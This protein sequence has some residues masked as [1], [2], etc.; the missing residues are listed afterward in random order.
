M[1]AMTTAALI[2]CPELPSSGLR[3]SMYNPA[4]LLDLL[5]IYNSPAVGEGD[6]ISTRITTSLISDAI[7]NL[8]PTS[9]YGVFA[10]SDCY[11]EMPSIQVLKTNKTRYWQLGAIFEDEGTLSGTYAVHRNIFIDQLRLRKSATPTKYDDFHDRLWLVHGDQLISHHIRSVKA[12]QTEALL[13][14]DR[15]DWMLG[16]PAWFHIQMNLLNTIVRT[17]WASDYSGYEAH[18]CLSADITMWNRSCSSR[19]N[20]KYHQI[21]PIATQGF[22]GRVAALFYSA[23]QERGYFNGCNDNFLANTDYINEIISSLKPPQF[24]QLVED[25]RLAAFTLNAWNGDGLDK[26]PHNDTEFRTMCRMLQEMELFLTVR[27]AVKNADIGM[28]RRLVDPLIIVFFGASQHN[29]GREMLYYRWLLSPVN[30]PE[31]QHAIL[32]SGI[33]NWP[34]RAT[35]HKPIDLGHEHMNGNIAISI[36]SYKNSTHDTDIIFDRMCLSNTYITSLRSAIEQE[37][38]ETMPGTYTTAGV[39]TDMFILARK[40]FKDNLAKPRSASQLASFLKQFDSSDILRLG[41]DVLAERVDTFNKEHVRQGGVIRAAYDIL[42]IEPS[43]GFGDI[44]SY[45]ANDDGDI[46]LDDIE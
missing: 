6:D 32:A 3:Q 17:H 25:V 19:D 44:A 26:Q 33:V 14:F 41:V 39:E 34:G 23:M 9:V 29:Y 40:L 4:I 30:T 38:G 18:H 8:H 12:A 35:T 1:R 2:L 5:D 46:G 45:V 13:P 37:F 20:A 11:P 43:N 10:E 28:L 36:R 22:T 27:H 21:E 42:P 16:V 31:L 15:R 7:K 24:L